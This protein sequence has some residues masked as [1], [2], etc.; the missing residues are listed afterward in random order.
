MN[1]VENCVE[2]VDFSTVF[3]L[4]SSTFPYFAVEKPVEKVEKWHS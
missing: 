2:I 1:Y 3:C 4:L